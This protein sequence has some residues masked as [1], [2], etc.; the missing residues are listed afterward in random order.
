MQSKVNVD[1]L[2]MDSFKELVLQIPV[3]KITIK[4]I[5][6][7]AGVIRPTFYNHFQDK[8]EVIE[9]IISKEIIVPM[10][11]LLEND[12]I[13]EAFT[14]LF[15]NIQ[16][17]GEYYKRLAKMEGQNSLQNITRR[18]VKEG[19]LQ[20]IEKRLDLKNG[21]IRLLTPI[22]LAEYYAQAVCFVIFAWIQADMTASPREMSEL[23]EYLMSHSMVDAIRDMQ[24]T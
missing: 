1:Q 15:S 19:L 8:Y 20:Y 7:K 13:I 11:V 22:H 21:T 10:A 12:M 9:R 24:G 17:D 14:L 2:L 23:C 6:D 4:E 3:E 18:S 16:K 5:T